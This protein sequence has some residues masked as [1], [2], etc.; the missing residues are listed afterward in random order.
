MMTLTHQTNDHDF[1]CDDS[2]TVH[3]GTYFAE[4]P[5]SRLYNI[6]PKDS[7]IP[8]TGYRKPRTI[9]DIKGYKHLT[10]STCFMDHFS[11]LR[12]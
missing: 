4:K 5:Y 10:V 7:P 12:Q 3:N 1:Y 11:K 9:M 8:T 6:V 2:S